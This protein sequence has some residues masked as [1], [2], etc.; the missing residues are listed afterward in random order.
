M[1][2]R[3]GSSIIAGSRSSRVSTTHCSSMRATAVSEASVWNI[4]FFDGGRIVWP[5][6]PALT[7]H[8]DAAAARRACARAGSR[9]R[10]VTIARAESATLSLGV[11]DEF[12][13]RGAPDRC[14]RRRRI[15]RRCRSDRA[16]RRMLR[17]ERV[18]G[19]LSAHRNAWQLLG[20]ADR[21]TPSRLPARVPWR[22]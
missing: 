19:D 17:G 22:H 8:I 1:S 4:G 20:A 11:P 6:A 15:R 12:V 14:D 2:A 7:R 3:S 10:R 13:V 18:A 16:A 21:A 9:R 5:N